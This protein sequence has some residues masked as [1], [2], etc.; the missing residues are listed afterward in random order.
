MWHGLGGKATK[1]GKRTPQNFWWPGVCGLVLQ[2]LVLFLTK[3]CYFQIT[4]FKF[5]TWA[6]KFN[7]P[8][9]DLAPVVQRLDNFIQWIWHYSGSKIYFMLNIVQG[10][11]TLPNLA[12][13]RVCIFICTQGNTVIFAQIETLR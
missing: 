7:Y 2:T 9:S 5:Q 1:C 4:Y 8:F 3:I 11:R 13:V 6:L 12:V 10:F